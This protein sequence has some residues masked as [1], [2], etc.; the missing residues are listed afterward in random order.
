[1]PMTTIGRIAGAAANCL[2]LT[3][4]AAVAEE[5]PELR[6]TPGARIDAAELKDLAAKAGKTLYAQRLLDNLR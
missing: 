6:S 1:M 5:H 3:I 4:A 2:S